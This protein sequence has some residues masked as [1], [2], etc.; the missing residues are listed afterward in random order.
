MTIKKIFAAAALMLA[1]AMNGTAAP[2]V[3]KVYIFGFATSFNDSTV[4]LTNIQ[5]VDSAWLTKKSNFL[6]G[7][8]NYSS[9]L[10]EYLRNKSITLPTCATF[11]NVKRK[12]LEKK[13]I[14]L[15]KKYGTGGKF[16]VK[17]VYSDQFKFTAIA[18]DSQYQEETKEAK[19]ERKAAERK[20][21]EQMKNQKGKDRQG[22][23]NGGGMSP[24]GGGMGSG[25]GMGPGGMPPGNGGM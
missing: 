16:I 17:D 21:R 5:E 23:P 25:G 8:D 24:G 22:P 6:I 3:A 19:K 11:F 1:V 7:R 4:Y 18:P 14:S 12:D 20:F 13:Y 15:R 2:K 10:Q 9:Q